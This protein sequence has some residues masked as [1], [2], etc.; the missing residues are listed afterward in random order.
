M[1]FRAHLILVMKL[2]ISH[3]F[4]YDH[5]FE[6]ARKICC[7]YRC[8]TTKKKYNLIIQLVIE[9]FQFKE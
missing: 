5:P 2:T 1:H 3:N 4:R 6:M 8:Q 9:I 7:L